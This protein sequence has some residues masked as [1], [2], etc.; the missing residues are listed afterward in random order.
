MFSHDITVVL[1]VFLAERVCFFTIS[2]KVTSLLSTIMFQSKEKQADSN[3]L[4]MS[5]LDN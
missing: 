3:T 4:F 1:H 5:L 2:G